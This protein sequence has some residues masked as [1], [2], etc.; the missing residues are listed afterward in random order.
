MNRRACLLVSSIILLSAPVALA[1]DHQWIYD[2]CEWQADLARGRALMQLADCD[3][4][5]VADVRAQFAQMDAQVLPT[6][7]RSYRPAGSSSPAPAGA[8]RATPAV[9]SVR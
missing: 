7:L 5:L 2:R 8:P 4:A 3:A 9:P 6:Y 1:H